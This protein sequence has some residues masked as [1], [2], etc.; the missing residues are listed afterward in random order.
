MNLAMKNESN[1]NGL[2]AFL[3]GFGSLGNISGSYTSI[4][5]RTRMSDLDALRS[6]WQKVGDDIRTAMNR[7]D[8][9]LWK[10]S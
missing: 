1:I 3:Y 9:E 8:S 2:R 5:R 7:Y 10:R 4:R 6:D